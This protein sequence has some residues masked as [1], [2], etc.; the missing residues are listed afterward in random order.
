MITEEIAAYEFN[1]LLLAVVLFVAFSILF[2]C[3]HSSVAAV[4]TTVYNNSR[5]GFGIWGTS[6]F[7]FL[8]SL[9]LFLSLLIDDSFY[10]LRAWIGF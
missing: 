2:L 4:S 8:A 5:I 10:R 6:M 9:S 3:S 7:G 1:F